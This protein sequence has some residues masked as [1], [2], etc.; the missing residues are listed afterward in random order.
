MSFENPRTCRAQQFQNPLL[1]PHTSFSGPPDL[2]VVVSIMGVQ[3]IP[4]AR[5]GRTVER[6]EHHYV[7]FAKGEPQDRLQFE[8]DIQHEED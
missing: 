1:Q 3:E 6:I 2:F 7:R 8:L 5:Y 4:P